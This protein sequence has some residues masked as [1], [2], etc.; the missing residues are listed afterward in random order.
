MKHILYFAL[1]IS[2]SIAADEDTAQLIIDQWGSAEP[3]VLH[4]PWRHT[5]PRKK[6][7]APT[8]KKDNSRCVFCIQTRETKDAENYILARFQHFAVMM[9]LFPYCPGHLLVIP[10]EHVDSISSLSAEARLELIEIL[11]ASIDTLKCE[12]GCDGVNVGLNLGKAA[13]ASI[14]DHLHVHILPRMLN[15]YRSFIQVLG[16]TEVA[17][18][19]LIKMYTYLKPSFDNLVIHMHEN[20]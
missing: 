13:G 14:P 17:S 15:D 6:A 12:L 20:K 2:M 11:S 3:A 18:C 1:F 19:D 4:A 8:E 5:T 16:K 10:Y 9:N 7:P